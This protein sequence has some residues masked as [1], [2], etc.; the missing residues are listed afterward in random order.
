VIQTKAK[1]FAQR[2]EEARRRQENSKS[3]GYYDSRDKACPCPQYWQSKPE[4]GEILN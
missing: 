2:E 3:E 4:R 1:D